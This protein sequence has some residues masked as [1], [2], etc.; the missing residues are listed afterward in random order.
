MD[1]P[2]AS[3]SFDERLRKPQLYVKVSDSLE[4]RLVVAL[5]WYSNK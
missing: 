3:L 5:S 2:F 4:M 1:L